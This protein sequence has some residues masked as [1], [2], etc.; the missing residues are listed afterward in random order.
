MNTVAVDKSTVRD[1][2][3]TIYNLPWETSP[4]EV[5]IFPRPFYCRLLIG[6][7]VCGNG[8]RLM[9]IEEVYSRVPQGSSM[10]DLQG[11]DFS[12]LYFLAFLNVMSYVSFATATFSKLRR[13]SI[14][15]CMWKRQLH[16]VFYW[17]HFDSVFATSSIKDPLRICVEFSF[18]RERIV[19]SLQ[20]KANKK[21]LST[22]VME[23][24][25]KEC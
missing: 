9:N 10:V 15:N 5:R 17:S 4:G 23:M 18:V 12:K 13:F 14:A 6:F 2:S 24:E 1:K 11:S 3:W 20:R 25:S 8:I 16:C 22:D 7:Q 21:E 19:A